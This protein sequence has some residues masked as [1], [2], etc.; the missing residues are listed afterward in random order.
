MGRIGVTFFCALCVLALAAATACA[1]ISGPGKVTPGTKASFKVSGLPPN[2]NLSVKLTVAGGGGVNLDR[3]YVSNASGS[4]KIGFNFP[5]RY[6]VKLSCDSSY[7]ECPT[8]K[9][10]DGQKVKFKVCPKG[11]ACQTKGLKVRK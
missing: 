11:A 5:K 6:N 10:S 2:A 9:F 1:S 4:D 7:A 3:G 8:K